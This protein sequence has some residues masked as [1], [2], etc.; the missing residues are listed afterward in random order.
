M[1]GLKVFRMG[2]GS[3]WGPPSKTY[4]TI[5]QDPDYADL[6]TKVLDYRLSHTTHRN[7]AY[8]A[9]SEEDEGEKWRHGTGL[10][11]ER[12]TR[13]LYIEYNIGLG[14]SPWLEKDQGY[15]I[16]EPEEGTAKKDDVAWDAM[17]AAVKSR[18]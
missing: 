17:M 3:W 2:H 4:Y 6:D 5:S 18:E 13:M 1:K 14:P 15:E 9:P 12:E 10:S 7:F 11:D 8:P 16:F